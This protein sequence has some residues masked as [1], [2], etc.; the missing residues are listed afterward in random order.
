MYPTVQSSGSRTRSAVLMKLPRLEGSLVSTSTVLTTPKN[1]QLGSQ[2]PTY[3]A[4][5]LILRAR[6]LL[7]QNPAPPVANQNFT[8]FDWKRE[9]VD[10]SGLPRMGFLTLNPPGVLL[11]LS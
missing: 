7:R 4:H 1:R 6:P 10:Q 2:S 5:G 11:L 3:L 8:V 9:K